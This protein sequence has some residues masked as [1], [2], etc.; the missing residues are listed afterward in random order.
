METIK[1]FLL[2]VLAAVIA[3]F[4]TLTRRKSDIEK[5]TELDERKEELES[6]LEFIEEKEKELEEEGVDSLK[7]EEVVNYWKDNSE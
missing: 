1:I 6:R 4:A 2:G 3:I 7:P 5:P